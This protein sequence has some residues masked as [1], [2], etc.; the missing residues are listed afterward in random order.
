MRFKLATTV[1]VLCAAVLA[2]GAAA[3]HPVPVNGVPMFCNHAYTVT[4]NT[5]FDMRFTWSVKSQ[6]QAANFLAG[7]QFSWTVTDVDTEEELAARTPADY[8]DQTGWG[9]PVYGEG[10]I[11]GKRQK[12]WGMTYRHTLTLSPDQTVRISYTLSADRKT[13]DGFGFTFDAFEVI[14]S[15]STCTVTGV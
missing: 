14:S 8:G 10:I 13:D 12:Y 15:A 5:P 4:A 6:G 1:A 11:E 7:Q 2:P 9:A 3:N